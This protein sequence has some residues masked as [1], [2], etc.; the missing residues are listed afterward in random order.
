MLA[1]NINRPS[2]IRADIGN[3]ANKSLDT[4]FRGIALN[5]SADKE[6][7]VKVT[8]SAYDINSVA[9]EIRFS[10]TIFCKWYEP[11]LVASVEDGLNSEFGD[12]RKGFK[13]FEVLWTP[14]FM[15]A[16]FIEE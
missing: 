3:I 1:G 7:Q 5:V 11:K 15:Y 10:L 12:D 6:V 2:S 4:S 16:N 14:S 8:C 13:K 9:Q